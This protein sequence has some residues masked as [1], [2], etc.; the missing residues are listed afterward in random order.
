MAIFAKSCFARIVN[1][2]LKNVCKYLPSDS[3]DLQGHSHILEINARKAARRP[4]WAW[5]KLSHLDTC[6]GGAPFTTQQPTSAWQGVAAC[7]DQSESRLITNL[8]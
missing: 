7:V 3:G 4:L 5:P 1:S 6:A 8:K 2:E